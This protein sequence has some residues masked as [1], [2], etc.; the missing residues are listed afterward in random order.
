MVN[1]RF[2]GKLERI[3]DWE[4]LL[5][6]SKHPNGYAGLITTDSGMIKLPREL[7]VVLQTKFSLVVVEEA[8]HDPLIAS[9]LVLAHLPQICG[10]W[11]PDK[12]QVF[13]LRTSSL[14]PKDP[15][16]FLTKVSDHSNIGVNQLYKDNKLTDEELAWDPLQPEDGP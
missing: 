7:C 16:D 2:E 6:L 12:A 11:H 13:R 9:G 4:L 15:W 14:R 5:A 10:K 1:K 3:D 8:G